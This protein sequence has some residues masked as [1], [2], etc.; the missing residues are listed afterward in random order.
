MSLYI[1]IVKKKYLTILILIIGTFLFHGCQQSSDFNVTVDQFLNDRDKVNAIILDVRTE[2]EYNNGHLENAILINIHA[3]DFSKKIKD[4]SKDETYYVYCRSGG[5][6]K[7]AVRMMRK[8]GLS[9][10]YNIKGGIL[11]LTRKGIKLVN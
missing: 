4:L 1:T 6:S 9:K 10:A 3:P 2:K 7:S 5:R 8:E 11:Q